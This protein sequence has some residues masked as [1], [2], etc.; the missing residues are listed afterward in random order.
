MQSRLQILM[1]F[2]QLPVFRDMRQNRSAYRRV[3]DNR[4]GG[5]R[6]SLVETPALGHRPLIPEIALG[7]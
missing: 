7:R 3:G 5:R 2:K 6:A 4:S 1:V